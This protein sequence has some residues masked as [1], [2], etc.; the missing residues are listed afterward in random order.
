MDIIEEKLQVETKNMQIIRE[1][2]REQC[3]NQKKI[4][5]DFD[6]RCVPQLFAI[7]THILSDKNQIDSLMMSDKMSEIESHERIEKI[8]HF[9]RSGEFAE[10]AEY[11]IQVDALCDNQ[12]VWR[13]LPIDQQILFFIKLL[14]SYLFDDF[15]S[16]LFI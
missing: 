12:D 5:S 3:R 13:L 2:S 4:A 8:R 15:V 10:V 16:I 6:E 14:K 9:L 11:I 1:K 7:F